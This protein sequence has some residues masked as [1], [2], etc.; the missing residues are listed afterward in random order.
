MDY[1]RV[2]ALLPFLKDP[3]LSDEERQLVT[4]TLKSKCEIL[5]RGY[6]KHHNLERFAEVQGYQQL[7]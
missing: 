4:E 3:R 2:K 6:Q 5:L 1:W 7:F